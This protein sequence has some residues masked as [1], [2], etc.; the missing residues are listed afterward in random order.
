MRYSKSFLY[1][2][3]RGLKII[4]YKE[5]LKKQKIIIMIEILK[6]QFINKT[7]KIISQTQ[8]YLYKFTI[9]QGIPK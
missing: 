5:V 3:Q 7:T 2:N 1:K 4:N 8:I 6:N 9:I